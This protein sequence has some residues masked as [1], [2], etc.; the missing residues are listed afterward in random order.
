MSD[1]SD[2][3]DSVSVKVGEAIGKGFGETSVSE[4]AIEGRK[5][6]GD[7]AVIVIGLII[8]YFLFKIIKKV[9]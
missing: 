1:F 3:V 6:A 7:F 8:G 9:A 4:S 2:W 5:A